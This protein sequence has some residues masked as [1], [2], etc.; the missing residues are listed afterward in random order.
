MLDVQ[1]LVISFILLGIV[2]AIMMWWERHPTRNPAIFCPSCGCV[3]EK[4]WYDKSRKYDKITGKGLAEQYMRYEC[5]R[6][7]AYF[8]EDHYK[9]NS[10]EKRAI[11]IKPCKDER[12][13]SA[14]E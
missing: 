13:I 7:E 4:V 9:K 6:W 14:N 2:V 10:Y 11:E 12:P 1:I 8:D 5:P 3:I